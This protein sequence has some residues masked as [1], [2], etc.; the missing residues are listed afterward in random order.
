MCGWGQE[1]PV[2]RIG[3]CGGREE[4][5]LERKKRLLGEG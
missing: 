3:M 1:C 4:C 2:G 5:P